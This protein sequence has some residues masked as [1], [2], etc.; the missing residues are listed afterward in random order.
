MGEFLDMDPLKKR[1]QI[2]P[3]QLSFVDDPKKQESLLQIVRKMV[4][5]NATSMI[6]TNF[7]PPINPDTTYYSLRM[8]RDSIVYQEVKRGHEK[9]PLTYD[10]KTDSLVDGAQL[11][12]DDAET[13]RFFDVIAEISKQLSSGKALLFDEMKT[14]GGKI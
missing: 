1:E 8:T 10:L 5:R 3:N 9:K 14:K 12:D 13:S 11:V 4:P 7:L 6:I 2:L